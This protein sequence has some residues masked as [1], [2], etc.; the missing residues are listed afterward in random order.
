[1]TIDEYLAMFA[2]AGFLDAEVIWTGYDMALDRA[3]T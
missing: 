3:H 1:M 2:N